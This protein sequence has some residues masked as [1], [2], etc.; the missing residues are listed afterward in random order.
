MYLTSL[1]VRDVRNIVHASISPGPGFN[2]FYG[3]NGA[4][5]TSLLESIAIL[6]TGRSFRAGKIG[7]V[8]RSDQD[9]LM[10]AAEIRRQ[11]DAPGDRIG[12]QR[13]RQET[14]VRINGQTINKISALAKSLPCA[15]SYTHLTLPTICSV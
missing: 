14:T 7:S 1:D 4:G 10:I 2:L 5:K 15:V 6:S 9:S 12:L 8:I 11:Q 13:G 3:L